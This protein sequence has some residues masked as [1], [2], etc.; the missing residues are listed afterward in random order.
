MLI[1][2]IRRNI[3]LVSILVFAFVF[4]IFQL[5]KPSFLYEKDGALREFGLG[6]ERKTI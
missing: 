1:T 3:P 6:S 2:F 5:M 4:Y